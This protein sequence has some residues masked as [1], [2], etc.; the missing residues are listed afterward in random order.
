M[1]PNVALARWLLVYNSGVAGQ[2]DASGPI[3]LPGFM[4]RGALGLQAPAE[5]LRVGPLRKISFLLGRN[6]HGK[7]TLL[8]ASALFAQRESREQYPIAGFQGVERQV[9]LP[10]TD[11]LLRTFMAVR[12]HNEILEKVRTSPLGLVAGGELFVWVSLGDGGPL[13][14]ALPRI[15]QPQWA[16]L[17]GAN[18]DLNR[19]ATALSQSL[20]GQAGSGRSFPWR[21]VPA[22]REIRPH[23]PKQ[24][25][26]SAGNRPPAARIDAG[27]GLLKELQRWQDPPTEPPETYEALTHRFQQ[28]GDFVRDVLEDDSAEI[29]VRYDAQT[30]NVKTAQ[31]SR[32]LPLEALGDGIKQVVM[33]AAACL[34]HEETLVCLEEPE[35][36]LHPGLQRKLVRHLAERTRNQYLIATH[37][38]HLLDTPGAAVFHVIHDGTSTTVSAAHNTADLRAVCDDLGY[39]PSDLLQA[40]YVIWVEGP[41]DR[42]YWRRWISLVDPQ[43]TEGVH[44]TLIPY[45]GRLVDDLQITGESASVATLIDEMDEQSGDHDAERLRQDL[46][47][48]LQLGRH[49]TLIADSDKSSPD[50]ELGDTVRRLGEEAQTQGTG[51]LIV[52]EWARTVE[53]LV[54]PAALA[55]AVKEIHPKMGETFRGPGHPFA[56]PF[57]ELGGRRFS[58]PAVA[59]RVVTGLTLDDMDPHLLDAVGRLAGAIREANGLPIPPETDGPADASSEG[60]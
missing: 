54:P 4:V 31:A 19:L 32:P 59:R 11:D 60:S 51:D 55:Q 3:L 38:A 16:A 21:M 46:I 13:A 40:N 1:P 25:V 48:L 45:G 44:Y 43:L 12:S 53:N 23:E 50:D 42:I 24:D 35:I 15:Q 22:F 36:H 10:L 47:D 34:R 8:R 2:I 30:L 56:P 27:E 26:Q 6:N 14:V 33:L 9:L 41:A 29:R 28:L 52:C 5:A 37:S 17:F 49:C 58:K 57:E 20:Q 39:R 7:S 18:P